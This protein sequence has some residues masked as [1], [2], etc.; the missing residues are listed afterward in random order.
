MDFKS[1]GGAVAEYVAERDALRIW[2]KQMDEEETRRK[3]K[4]TE[5]EVWLLQKADALGVDSFKTPAG[6]AYKA[7]QEHFRVGDWGAICDYVRRTNNFSIFEKRIAKLAT[8]EVIEVEGE[9]PKGIVYSSEY[10]INV[11][12]PSKKKGGDN[13]L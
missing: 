10:T 6:T 9:I 7:K 4:L 12:R 1:I 5:I 11:L 2:K 3:A 8:K 13:E